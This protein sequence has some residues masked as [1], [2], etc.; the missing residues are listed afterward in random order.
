[1]EQGSLITLR[2]W[3]RVLYEKARLKDVSA[4]HESLYDYWRPQAS[5]PTDRK[6]FFGMSKQL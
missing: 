5:R 1:M 4:I 2:E 6:V 3:L